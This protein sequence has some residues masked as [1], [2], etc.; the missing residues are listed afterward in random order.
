MFRFLY[1]ILVDEG[2]LM[3]CT[4][5]DL[6]F[7]FAACDV[8]RH[9]CQNWRIFATVCCWLL[10]LAKWC[11]ALG[12]LEVAKHFLWNVINVFHMQ[13]Q[14]CRLVVT[15]MQHGPF[16]GRAYFLQAGP[17]SAFVGYQ[18]ET[19]ET[20]CHV[21]CVPMDSNK[22]RMHGKKYETSNNRSE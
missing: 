22:T 19:S 15:N 3:V 9:S 20:F 8:S 2:I 1:I 10:S 7:L 13:I 6:N 21:F 5:C 11:P 4:L 18:L 17:R 14:E 16:G 12:I